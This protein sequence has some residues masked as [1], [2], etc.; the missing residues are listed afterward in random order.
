MTLFYIV[1]FASAG[2]LLLSHILSALLQGALSR[3]AGYV[4]CVLSALAFLSASYIWR[5]L[6]VSLL[7]L[8]GSLLFY[9]LVSL[10][11]VAK[12]RRK[13]DK[14]EGGV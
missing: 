4:G 5:S 13:K 12:S 10:L 1:F 3:A 14:G 6:E 8:F 9:L 11:P 2:L 7:V